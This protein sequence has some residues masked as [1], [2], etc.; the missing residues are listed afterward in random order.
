MD[1]S[2]GVVFGE[3]TPKFPLP[4]MG[5]NCVADYYCNWRIVTIA[6]IQKREIQEMDC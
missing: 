4:R 3:S 5:Q 2:S 1:G 6:A